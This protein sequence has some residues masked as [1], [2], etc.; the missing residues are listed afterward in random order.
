MGQAM[1][2]SDV[3]MLRSSPIVLANQLVVLKVV[4]F[5]VE[6]DNATP[7]PFPDSELELGIGFSR[8]RLSQ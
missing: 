2:S 3:R 1:N 8:P 5:D 4:E 6:F 7:P